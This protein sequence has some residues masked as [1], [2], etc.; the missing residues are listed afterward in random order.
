M[1]GL[2]GLICLQFFIKE[3]DGARSDALHRQGAKSAAVS[4]PVVCDRS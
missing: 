1:A 3:I 2:A 4:Q